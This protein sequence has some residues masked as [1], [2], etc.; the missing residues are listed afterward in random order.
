VT[1][2]KKKGHRP[3]KPR[4][5]LKKTRTKTY[6]DAGR[7][8]QQYR[9]VNGLPDQKLLH[10][11]IKLRKAIEQIEND[12]PPKMRGFV[13]PARYKAAYGGRGSSK[14]HS[15]ASLI[16]YRALTTPGLRAVCIREVQKSIA[17]SVRQ[18]IV[19]KIKKYGVEEYF[20]IQEQKIITPGNGLI[21]F[22]GMQNHTSD[23]IKS[24]EGFDIAWVEEA[25]SISEKSLRLL[26][27]TIRKDRHENDYVKA[28]TNTKRVSNGSELWFS[29]NPDSPTDP[30]D[31]F[32]RG[33]K[34][35]ADI[36]MVRMN[37]DDNPYFP[38]VLREEMEY[39]KK[40]DFESG[41]RLSTPD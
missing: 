7:L 8:E 17:L 39:D 10:A 30:I 13:N 15:F 22:Q 36:M 5:G 20:E 25:Q 19:D 28:I 27:P 16:V 32:L 2:A 18:L 38:D 29:W 41:E 11:A 33:D 24:L 9:I 14:S 4:N 6:K 40:R 26:R 23:S 3:L 12:L 31:E 1:T 21:I 34:P 35:P 37:Y